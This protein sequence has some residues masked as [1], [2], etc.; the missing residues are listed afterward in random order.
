[1]LPTFLPVCYPSFPFF[2][3]LIINKLYLLSYVEG[4]GPGARFMYYNEE[5]LWLE[6]FLTA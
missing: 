5:T 1:M 3:F 2:V 4:T 6:F